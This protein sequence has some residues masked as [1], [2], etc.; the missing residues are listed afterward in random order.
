MFHRLR[1][2][3]CCWSF[4]AT[5]CRHLPGAADRGRPE[6]KLSLH[7]RHGSIAADDSPLPAIGASF[8]LT[9]DDRAGGRVAAG[10]RCI[11]TGGA[12]CARWRSPRRPPR[13]IA[14][15]PFPADGGPVAVGCGACGCAILG[16][17]PRRRAGATAGRT[18]V[19]AL[20]RPGAH[21]ASTIR[22]ACAGADRHRE[23]LCSLR[24]GPR[25][26]AVVI[27]TSCSTPWAPATS[28][29]PQPGAALSRG[30]RG[31]CGNRATPAPGRDHGRA[32]SR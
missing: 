10:R 23:G 4:L 19:R 5:V 21:A 14:A 11:V 9:A 3:R 15:A 13:R 16:L 6:W 17:A 25:N 26:T 8:A 24:R 28:T 2:A 32:P 27:A 7:R 1:I 20:P 31:A 18:P 22:W 29:T 12:C 30:L